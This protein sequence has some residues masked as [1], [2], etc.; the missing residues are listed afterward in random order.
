VYTLKEESFN[1]RLIRSATTDWQCRPA[2]KG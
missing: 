1:A 2:R